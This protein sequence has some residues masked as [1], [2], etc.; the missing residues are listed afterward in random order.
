MEPEFYYPP[1]IYPEVTPLHDSQMD[2]REN[3]RRN[4][5]ALM[6]QEFGRGARG[7]QS[8]LAERL[9]KAQS[10]ISRY[11]A[12]PG[13][14]GAKDIGEDF[15]REVEKKFCLTRNSLDVEP[16]EFLVSAHRIHDDRVEEQACSYERGA[17]ASAESG[18]EDSSDVRFSLKPPTPKSPGS[19][20]EAAPSTLETIRGLFDRVTP[21]T[22]SVVKKIEVLAEQGRLTDEDM[23]LLE[24]II[25]RF[26]KR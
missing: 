24:Q 12:P 23:D 17:A 9:D 18:N 19:R 13:K 5:Q 22:R 20:S 25:E 14:P 11:L 2:T 7:A 16:G 8:R 26:N 21:R 4:L 15:A 3:R 1:V 10:L 6:D